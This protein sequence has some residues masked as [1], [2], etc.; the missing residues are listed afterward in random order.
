MHIICADLLPP[1]SLTHSLR[2]VYI[3][4][5]S[6][7]LHKV[8][9]YILY[10]HGCCY[11]HL[12]LLKAIE[13]LAHMFSSCLLLFSSEYQS[14]VTVCLHCLYL[15]CIAVQ[16]LVMCVAQIYP[17]EHAGLHHLSTILRVQLC[18]L[19]PTRWLCLQ[20]SICQIGA[21]LGNS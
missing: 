9:D 21:S 2:I 15:V 4:A 19:M 1:L 16:L 17:A 6:G 8:S 7:Q 18:R 5:T 11:A 14:K 12:S 10:C 20:A 3:A 13:D